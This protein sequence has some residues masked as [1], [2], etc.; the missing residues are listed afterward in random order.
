LKPLQT[1]T[2]FLSRNN[3]RTLPADYDGDVLVWDIDKTYLETRFSSLRGLLSI[4]FEWASDKVAAP[5]AVALL[6]ALRQG[7]DDTTPLLTPLYFIS[8]S[9]KELRGVIER[10]M[11]LDGVQVDGMTFKDQRGLLLSLRPKAIV[12]QLGYKTL[13]LCLLR[14]EL[15][16][17]VRFLCFGDDVERDCEAF[18]LFGQICGGLRGA[19]LR[20]RLRDGGVAFPEVEAILAVVDAMPTEPD[21]VS[22]VYVRAVR[23][24][25]TAST[26]PRVRVERSYTDVAR[27]LLHD[28]KISA[29]G[30]A[31]VAAANPRGNRQ[32]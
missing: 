16:T 23:H 13:A 4:P 5:G 29:S 17:R 25:A 27:H 7:P 2:R 11:I 10:K 6:R 30:A 21:P 15:P 12:E 20:Q 32:P 8:G 18:L 28:K 22:H 19:S 31:A 9:P 1:A 26:D 24:S 14:S 3:D